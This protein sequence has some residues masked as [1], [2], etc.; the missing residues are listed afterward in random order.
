M[1][2]KFAQLIG[3]PEDQTTFGYPANR[4][5]LKTMNRIFALLV[6]LA[7]TIAGSASAQE[8][9]TVDLIRAAVSHLTAGPFLEEFEGHIVKTDLARVSQVTDKAAASEQIGYTQAS[10]DEV[11][12]CGQPTREK[13]RDCQL[14]GTDFLVVV[15]EIQRTGSQ[16]TVV[17]DVH[18]EAPEPGRIYY[19]GWRLKLHLSR[20]GWTVTKA[21]ILY[22]VS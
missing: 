6:V 13:P 3:G 9:E 5:A 12:I 10:L 7:V 21:D 22:Q 17:I 2:K 14:E 20:T 15:K 16:A 4:E 1:L 11:R 8:N 19:T 18:G